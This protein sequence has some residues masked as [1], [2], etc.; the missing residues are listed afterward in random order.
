MVEIKYIIYF[1]CAAGWKRSSQSSPRSLEEV[2]KRKCEEKMSSG[3]LYDDQILINLETDFLILSEKV[4]SSKGWSGSIGPE[5]L[6]PA[7]QSRVERSRVESGRPAIK[8]LSH[9][10]VDVTRR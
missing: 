4:R 2:R 5:Q 3:Y 6:F 9:R 10:A 1:V 7:W 8:A